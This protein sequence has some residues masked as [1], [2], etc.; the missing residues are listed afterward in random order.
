M[1]LQKINA[2]SDV[3]KL[4]KDERAELIEDLRQEIISVTKENGGHLSSNLGILETTVALYKTFDFPKDKLIFDVGHQCYAHK[5]LSGR[6]E[7]FGTIRTAGGL[8]GFPNAE[9][10]GYDLFTT[11]HAGNSIALGLGLCAARDKNKEDYYVIT[12]VGDGA[13]VNGLNL[14]AINA[15]TEKPKKFIV[16]LNDNG[17]SI[18]RNRNGF[19]NFISKATTDKGYLK[20]K[21]AIKKL[22]GKSFIAVFFRKVRDFFKRL[23][24]KDQYFE[25]FGFK[26]VGVVDGNNLEKTAKTLERVKNAANYKAVFLHIKTT[27]GKG[28]K[29]A[30]ERSDLYHSVGK[31]LKLAGSDECS[32]GKALSELIDKDDKIVAITAGMKDGTGLDYLDKTHPDN[33]ID[34][35]IAEE[36]AVT[37]A[38]GMAKGGLKPVVAIYS[39][40]LQRAYDEIMQDVCLQDLPVVFCVDRAGFVGED[41]KT[42]QGLFDLSYT[43]H[44][45]NMTVLALASKHE[46]K[47]ALCYAI[48]L[49]RPVCIRYS[50]SCAGAEYF[51][52]YVNGAWETVKDGTDLTVIAVGANALTLATDFA[53]KYP[54]SIKVAAARIV[55]PLDESFLVATHTPVITIEENAVIGGFGSLVN[56]FCSAHNGNKV[57]SLGVKDGFVR[58][59]SIKGQLE[60]NGFNIENLTKI[61]DGLLK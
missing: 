60:E 37:F 54:K 31:N 52:D 47:A 22:F 50:K 58:H 17:M 40:F 46:L 57:Y 51:S 55:K 61:A 44:I 38:A 59:G 24:N 11:G 14:E 33:L 36:Y 25:R 49:N 10:S 6:R 3:K 56:A 41:G 42:H 30:E 53:D 21:S 32:L 39:T 26:Y 18:S 23:I 9:E 2:S 12:V 16:V 19:Y 15:S 28:L 35:G 5:L 1:V 13:L 43:L 45:P 27:K 4:N 20:S 7:L 48:S 34:V 29:N 8:S